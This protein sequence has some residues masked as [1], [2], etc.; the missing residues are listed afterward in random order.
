MTEMKERR[1]KYDAL[2]DEAEK[3][4]R[5]KLTPQFEDLEES[6]RILYDAEISEPKNEGVIISR[7][8]TINAIPRE[9]G[10]SSEQ[11]WKDGARVTGISNWATSGNGRQKSESSTYPSATTND[12]QETSTGVTGR[13]FRRHQGATKRY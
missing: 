7:R 1:E 9:N 5:A 3:Q 11:E 6:D 12:V 2:L 13:R 10:K 8:K 4:V